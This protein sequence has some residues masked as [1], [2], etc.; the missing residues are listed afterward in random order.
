MGALRTVVIGVVEQDHVARPQPAH[1]PP[2]DLLGGR[3]LAPVLAPL[4]PQQRLQ[5][6]L[7]RDSQAGAGCRSRMAGGAAAGATPVASAIAAV[8]ALEV[9]GQS[10]R[11]RGRMRAVG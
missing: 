8:A 2:G 4:G 3:D 6:A 7:A 1:D 11:L 10:L 5:A 9:V